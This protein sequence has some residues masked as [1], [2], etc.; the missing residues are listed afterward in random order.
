MGAASLI[1]KMNLKTY[2][3]VVEANVLESLSKLYFSE[4]TI[5]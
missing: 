3:Y 5:I 1:I 2:T 4:A